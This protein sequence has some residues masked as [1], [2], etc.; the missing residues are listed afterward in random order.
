MAPDQL[1]SQ[2]HTRNARNRMDNWRAPNYFPRTDT[3]TTKTYW[4]CRG[5]QD[6]GDEHGCPGVFDFEITAHRLSPGRG[7]LLSVLRGLGQQLTLLWMMLQTYRWAA[8]WT[9]SHRTRWVPF[10]RSS[11]RLV[12]VIVELAITSD[13][14]RWSPEY[15]IMQVSLL[16]NDENEQLTD[17]P[18]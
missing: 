11:F 15:A 2:N 5:L 1:S 13:G 4:Q 8:N 10:R 14:G 6:L 16:I 3:E 17:T 18:K 12:E 9:P 7:K